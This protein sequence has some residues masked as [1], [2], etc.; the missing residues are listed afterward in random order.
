MTDR[1]RDRDRDSDRG[2]RGRERTRDR[3]DDDRRSRGR[4][5]DRGGRSRDYRDRDDDRGGS[6][7]G[8]S[9]FHYQPRSAEQAKARSAKGAHDYDKIVKDD[10]KTWKPNN[11]LNRIRILPPTWD[12]ADHFGFDLHVHYGV[13]ADRGQYLD[14]NKMLG[15]PDPI[16]E[17]RLQASRDGDV[18]YAKDLESKRRV[19]IYLIDRDH[20]R[21]GV[22][23]WAMPWT[24][25][26]DIVKVS[27]DRSTGEVLPI[28]HPEDG[29]DVEFEKQGDK[30]RTEYVGVAIS[31][32]STPLGKDS[33][34]D[35]AVDHPIPEILQYFDYDHIAK[36]FG[37]GGDQRDSRGGRDDD[38]DSDRGGRDR[39]HE[40]EYSWDSVHQMS[41]EELDDLVEVEQLDIN[42][43]KF[44]SDDELADAI[45]EEM[46]L[47]KEER[48]QRSRPDD[49]GDQD[50]DPPRRGEGLSRM[51]E[52]R[53]SED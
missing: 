42:P 4:D 16:E 21:E 13:G 1:Y 32:R 39:R 52:R 9:S 31:R 51:R 14:L 29:F 46:G 26:R 48:R 43:N 33:W 44:D 35:H 50:R 27:M 49:D 22:Q 37:G 15:K 7:R 12:G 45:C 17:E 8:G 6:R 41:S 28:D 25:D 2:D 10:V 47:K 23:F 53:R 19:G 5:D 40:S 11:G 38:R 3:G 24:L 20:E 30:D 34:L 18:K 36:V